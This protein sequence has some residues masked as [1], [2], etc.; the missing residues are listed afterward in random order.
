[1]ADPTPLPTDDL[2]AQLD[3]LIA[4]AA[5]APPD[6][7]ADADPG[8]STDDLAAQLD[9]L[10]ANAAPSGSDDAP[11]D[12]EAA[13]DEVEGAVEAVREAVDQLETPGSEQTPRPEA[14]AE[15]KD[16]DRLANQ[17]QTLID[18]AEPAKADAKDTE[19]AADQ[20]PLIEQLDSL[21]ADHAEDALAGDFES[22]ESLLGRDDPAIG[23][24][25]APPESAEAPEAPGASPPEPEAQNDDE[26]D[27]GFASP[28]EVLGTASPPE[29][30]VGDGEAEAEPLAETPAE[31]SGSDDDA[32]DAFDG[33]DEIDG[34]F[35]APEAM[36]PRPSPPP[37]AAEASA[38]DDAGF[39]SDDGDGP[40]GGFA[41]LDT[42]LTADPPDPADADGA[43]TVAD[44]PAAGYDATDADAGADPETRAAGGWSVTL[45]A[46]ALRRAFQVVKPAAA[47]AMGWALWACVLINAPLGKVPEPWRQ[48]VGWSAWAVAGPGVLL[49]VYGLLT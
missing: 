4:R 35:E 33:L 47:W 13:L 44:K 37:P 45:N 32:E 38:D 10:M 22:V 17:L 3:A 46:A 49:I 48:A 26:L 7:D 24:D 11:A 15:P 42:L 36:T 6:P 39:E 43:P 25:A 8:G 28:D 23:D 1:M 40:D 30:A 5:D 41:S 16:G 14:D 12:V 29:P 20:P 18:E 21:L 19:D 27:G 9:A 34:L 2:E 31:P